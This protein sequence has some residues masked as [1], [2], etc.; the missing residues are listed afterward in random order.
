MKKKTKTINKKKPDNTK[1]LKAELSELKN[2]NIRLL[3]EFDNFKKRNLEDKR[4]LL[5]YDGLDF[6][7]SLLPIL[8]DIDR[9]L[10]LKELKS[11]KTIFDG[12]N[13]I[14]DK[15]NKTLKEKGVK[16]GNSSEKKF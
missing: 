12:I 10:S 11:N 1:K 7:I 13:M 16:T 5:K 3:A 9:T 4:K 6:I 15:I 14:R 8:D 2:K